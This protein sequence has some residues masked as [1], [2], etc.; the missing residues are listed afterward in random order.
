MRYWIIR[1]FLVFFI[2]RWERPYFKA[3]DKLLT[4]H[5]SIFFEFMDCV[6]KRVIKYEDME[7]TATINGN[8]YF[9]IKEVVLYKQKNRKE[10][11][12]VLLHELGHHHAYVEKGLLTEDSAYSY[13]WELVKKYGI[14]HLITSKDWKSHH[15]SNDP[16]LNKLNKMWY[17]EEE[18][19]NALIVPSVVTPTTITT[20]PITI[21][22]TNTIPGEQVGQGIPY[23]AYTD[24]WKN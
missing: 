12:M 15:V 13:G 11:L 17:E 22:Y 10:L 23:N 16:I 7:Y 1:K 14:D 5:R 19:F 4:D 3:I 20:N 18:K 9:D 6:N 2:P 8:Y 24:Q 21:T